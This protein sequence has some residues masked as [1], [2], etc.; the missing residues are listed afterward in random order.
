MHAPTKM[1]S[2]LNR[3]AHR[4]ISENCKVLFEN[5]EATEILSKTAVK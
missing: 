4:K 2:M 3:F 1:S 5:I